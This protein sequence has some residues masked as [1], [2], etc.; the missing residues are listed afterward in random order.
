M[1]RYFF[2]VLV[3]PPAFMN[4]MLVQAAPGNLARYFLAGYL[5]A[6]AP[7]V[8]IALTDEM[9]SRA[10]AAQRAG[11]CGLVGLLGAPVAMGLFADL[12]LLGKVQ[13]SLC[14]GLAAFLCALTCTRLVRGFTRPRRS[15]GA[16]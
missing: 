11:W 1:R 15:L 16:A 8:T 9:L 14:G 12:S 6:A 7:A 2:Y 4:L 10:S 13:A 5:V 3:F